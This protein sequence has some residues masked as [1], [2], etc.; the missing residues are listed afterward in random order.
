[1]SA[2]QQKLWWK[3]LKLSKSQK[4]K[5]CVKWICVY[6][7]AVNNILKMKLEYE[8][9]INSGEHLYSEHFVGSRDCS[10]L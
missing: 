1:M 5:K 2:K 7:G 9:L 10:L 3:S 6:V 4:P 8:N